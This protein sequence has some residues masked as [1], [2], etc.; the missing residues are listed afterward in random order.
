MLELSP[1]SETKLIKLLHQSLQLDPAVKSLA[2]LGEKHPDTVVWAH[3]HWSSLE[4]DLSKK[5]EVS[6]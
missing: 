3:D 6:L 5:K 4:Q 1:H 2:E